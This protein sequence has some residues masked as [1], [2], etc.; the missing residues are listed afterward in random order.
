MTRTPRR[1]AGAIPA[2]AA[3]HGTIPV[4]ACSLTPVHR[5]CRSRICLNFVLAGL[6]PFDSRTCALAVR[7]AHI[8]FHSLCAKQSGC[9]NNPP[10]LKFRLKSFSITNQGLEQRCAR[11]RTIL[12]TKNVKKRAE[13]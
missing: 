4:R 5:P 7:F 6:L 11:L 8:V 12:S 3:R 1:W 13:L 9:G 2:G 10:C